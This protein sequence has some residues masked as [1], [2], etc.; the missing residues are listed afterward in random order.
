M[1]KHARLFLLLASLMMTALMV[2][3]AWAA[4]AD[5]LP[6][7][8]PQ[9]QTAPTD[10]GAMPPL[11]GGTIKTPQNQLPGRPAA[12]QPGTLFQSSPDA[13]VITLWYGPTQTFGPKGDP[14]KWVNILGNVSSA[15]T[16]SSVSYSLNGGPAMPVPLGPDN[17]RLAGA[18]DFNIELDYTDLQTG[19]NQLVITA[20]DASLAPTQ[21]VVTINYNSAP[22]WTTP[23]TITVNWAGAT[24][25]SDVAQVIDGLWA[26]DNGGARP[27]VLDFDRLIGIGDMSWRDYTVTVPI[28]VFGIDAEGYKAPSNGPGVGVLVRWQGHYA[29]SEGESP[30]T[31]WRRLGGLGWYRWKKDGAVY[32]EGL[33]LLGNKGQLI[34]ESTRTL[35]VG[36]TYIFKLAIQSNPNPVKPA[37][38]RFKVWPA[39]GTEPATWDVEG[40]GINGEPRSGSLMLLAHHVDAR[41]GAVTVELNSIQPQPKLTISNSGTGTGTVA[42]APTKTTYRFGED[43]TLTA[44]PGAGSTFEGWLGD[45][46]GT[47]NPATLEMFGDRTATALFINPTVQTPI[48]DDFSSCQLNTQR[49]T[50]I[51]PLGDA[52]LSMTGSQVQIN[53][54]DGI[55]HD[56]WISGINAPRIMQY[57]E[58]EDFSFDVKFD[59]AMSQ[60]NQAQGVIVQGDE[61]DFLR[62]N[63][64]HDGK[65][66][67]VQVYTFLDGALTNHASI[68]NPITIAPPMYL[69][70]KRIGNVWNL[71]YSSDGVNW[72]LVKGFTFEMAVS[73]YGPYVG[74][75]SKNPAMVGLIDYF[76]NTNSPIVPEDAAR[77][78]NVTTTGSGA[79]ERLPNKENYACDESVTLTAVPGDGYKF[80]SW[81]GALSGNTNPA[82]LVMNET[83][84]VTANFVPAAQYTVTVSASGPGAVVRSPDKPTYTAGEE[85]TI[86]ATPSLGGAFTGW[87][88]DATGTTNPL[89]IEVSQ[90]TTIV[91]NFAAAPPRTLTVTTVGPG[92]V[93]NNPPGTSFVSGTQVTLTATPTGNAAFVGWSGAL[94]GDANPATIIMDADKAVTATFKENVYS[95]TLS[96]GPNGTIEAVPSKPLYYDG[97]TVTLTATPALGYSFANW[98]GDLSGSANPATLVM[99][100]N[101][102][103]GAVFVSDGGYPVNV[104]VVG[105]GTVVKNPPKDEYGLGEQVI[106]TAT[107]AAGKE[108]VGWSGDLTGSVN[109]ATITV[110]GEMNITATFG[111]PG[112]YSLTLLPGANGSISADPQRPLYAVGEQVTLTAEPALGYMFTGWGG[113]ATGTTNPLIISMDGNKTISATFA[114]AP[115]Y[116][117]NVTSSGNGDVAVD[118]PGTQFLAGTVVTLTATADSGYVFAGWSGDLVSNANP[119][120]LTVNGNKNIVANF[121]DATGPVSDDFD[122]CAAL[123]TM[124]SWADPLGEANY[125]MTGT[126]LKIA[127]PSGFDYEVWT[128]GNKGARIMQEIENTDFEVSVRMESAV[129]QSGQV[130]GILVEAS[131]QQ[132]IRFDFYRDEEALKLFAGRVDNGAPRIFKNKEPDETL[133]A[134]NASVMYLMVR[135]TGDEWKLFY[136]SDVTKPWTNFVKFYYG[137]DAQR[138]G[139]FAGSQQPKAGAPPGHTALFDFFFNT[140]S[141]ISPEDANAPGLS[142]VTAGQGT[143]TP[144]P[145]A[146]YTCGQQVQLRATPLTGWQFQD[147]RG[148]LTGSL[149]TQTLT[150]TKKHAVTA[151]FVLRSRYDLFMPIAIR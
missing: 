125:T 1:N 31:G 18:G 81:S 20:V 132:F 9:G 35:N 14:Q 28:T 51:N 97:E 72:P 142:V 55:G 7:A 86:T 54:P 136:R 5:L 17:M 126:Q 103:V 11:E 135:R 40:Q 69:R 105:Q 147:W 112:V 94:S 38:Y 87:S 26:I 27:T 74:N 115:L 75:S 76:F 144:T 90:N 70:V 58:N 110:T 119:Y 49:W 127:I 80:D 23:Q 104:A 21:A 121:T 22:A 57:A 48:S 56:V 63:F 36:T 8:L 114:V 37:I 123:S 116:T 44:T 66:Y 88:G 96:P 2:G 117:V 68:D 145:P 131:E 128:A 3:G 98:T 50:Y 65:T 137:I 53:V 106:L 122:S 89:V 118:P 130:Q 95:L 143:V 92:T 34:G 109:P 85:V 10:E 6:T 146:P 111:E 83:K 82:T 25:V 101:A 39:N 150:I 47:A 52:T 140:D 64:L 120:H 100:K 133:L 99:T 71:H 102:T 13:P 78:L 134:Q 42:A 12:D 141:P 91:G 15:V 59:S 41:F 32:S 79:V 108:F 45:L 77:K 24:K 139:V 4:E 148:D 60:K 84:N 62:F 16:I 46:T 61:G 124:W 73:S 151:T 43:V 93:A 138:I 67:R 149:A 19:A 113:D 33:Q 29:A 107:P 30:R 129:L